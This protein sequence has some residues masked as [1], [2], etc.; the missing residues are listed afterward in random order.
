MFKLITKTTVFAALL[1]IVPTVRPDFVLPEPSLR[2]TQVNC[3]L[4]DKDKQPY[5]EHLCLFRALT[6]FLHGHSNLDAH[7]SQLFAEFISKSGYDPKNFRGVSIDD[8][9]LV[10]EIVD[11][12]IFI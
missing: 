7:T 2:H 8:F 12:N 5:K 6:L 9:S 10:E 1:N 4:S 3:L 11:C